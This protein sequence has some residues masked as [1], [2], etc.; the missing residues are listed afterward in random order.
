MK[1]ESKGVKIDEENLSYLR[2]SND[3]VLFGNSTEYLKNMIVELN[4][5]SVKVGL[6]M[7]FN[8]TRVM[9]NKYIK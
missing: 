3:I 6:H 9:I 4:K 1:W 7:N 2:F 8:K 5:D